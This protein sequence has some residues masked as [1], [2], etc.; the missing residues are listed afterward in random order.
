MGANYF[1]PLSNGDVFD[2]VHLGSDLG[3]TF[4]AAA[5]A[6]TAQSYVTP[7]WDLSV[8]LN[9]AEAAT[10]VDTTDVG[11]FTSFWQG[12]AKTVVGYSIAKDAAQSGLTTNGGQN[13]QGG[14]NGRTG[15]APTSQVRG[16]FSPLLLIA[17]GLGALWVITRE[18]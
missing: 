8:N 17:A 6:N 12:I 3:N 13:S 1:D 9:A 2:G 15:T 18:G 4:D 7:K 10:P 11:N 14:A 5:N 16:G